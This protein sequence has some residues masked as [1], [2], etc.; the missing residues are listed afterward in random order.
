MLLIDKLM[1]I[2]IYNMVVQVVLLK[3]TY[4][5]NYLILTVLRL[6][7]IAFNLNL[8]LYKKYSG[9]YFIDCLDKILDICIPIYTYKLLIK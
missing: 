1:V 8:K 9:F 6:T 3:L 5:L 7:Y 4:L 2:Q